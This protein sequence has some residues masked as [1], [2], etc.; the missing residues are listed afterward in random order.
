MFP[1]LTI[2]RHLIAPAPQRLAGAAGRT[3]GRLLDRGSHR[4]RPARP[5]WRSPPSGSSWPRSS[6]PPTT[7]RHGGAV[8]RR[9]RAAP[10]WRYRLRRCRARRRARLGVGRAGHRHAA[11][12]A[13]DHG[14]RSSSPCGSTPST[15]PAPS[16][17]RASP[18]AGV[19]GETARP[20][21]PKPRACSTS[22]A[23]RARRRRTSPPH[24][25]RHDDR[26]R[27][28]PRREHPRVLQP[29]GAERWPPG[30]RSDSRQPAQATMRLGRLSTPATTRRGESGTAELVIAHPAAHPPAALRGRPRPHWPGRASTS[31]AP[32]RKPHG[33]RRS[34]ATPAAAPATRPAD[35]H[36]GAQ[37]ASTSP[38]PSLAVTTDTARFAPGGSVAVTVTC[39]VELAD[40]TG[41]RLPASR[42]DDVDRHVASS[43][44]TERQR[45][46]DPSAGCGAACGGPRPGW[47]PPSSS[48]SPSP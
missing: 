48:S 2:I 12:V 30:R 28:R 21:R 4:H 37:L 16:P 29:A 35:R 27:H 9:T 42:D 15:S 46:T 1:E 23:G 11:A 19:Q 33:P 24:G 20:A 6:P 10:P 31:T 43:T 26:R 40:L 41:L 32:P 36:R 13:L 17:N 25:R 44:P 18:S 5:P 14:G 7:S 45:M 8:T 34:P 38:A 47:S 3:R 39:A 22:S